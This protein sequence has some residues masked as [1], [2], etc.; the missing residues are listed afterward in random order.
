MD[1]PWTNKLYYGDNLSVL[2]ERLAEE[3]VDL[4]YLDPPFNSDADYNVLFKSHS[5]RT[6]EAQVEAFKDSWVWGEESEMAMDDVLR[7]SHTRTAEMLVSLRGFLK[8]CDLMAY[9]AMMASRMIELHRVLKETGTLYLHCDPTAAHYLKLLLDSI[10]GPERFQNEIIWQRSA[11]KG[12]SFTRFP[13]AH[14]IILAYRKGKNFTWNPIHKPHRPEYIASHYN[15]LDEATGRRYTL[16][17][18]LNPNKNRPNLTYEWNGLLK[19]WRWTRTKMQ[20]LH[21]EGR[22]VYTSSGMPRY[23]RYLDE[24]PGTT[25]TSVWTDIPPINS[26]SQERLGYPTQKPLALLERIIEAS[27][28]PGDVILD[29]FCG[30]GTAVHAAEALGRRWIGIDITHLA[31]ALIERR[32]HDAFPGADFSILGTPKDLASALDLAARDKYQFQWWAVS[33]VGARPYGGKKKGA[34][35]GIDGLLFFKPDGKNP[36]KAIVSVKGGENVGV[37]MV[38][39]LIAVIERE[40]APIG[41]LLTAALPT[42]G[43]EKE[44]ASAGIYECD[45]G[46][47]PRIQILTLAE[48]FQGARPRIP[49]IDS[50]I[51]FRTAPREKR[52]NQGALDI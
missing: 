14:D 1:A 37:D 10:F 17:N 23:K 27:S 29:P 9:L 42:K 26:Q 31:I 46:R 15:K 32:I 39:Q 13:S 11:P 22:L 51:T 12:H 24:M 5:G 44:A 2:R 43:M 47:Y 45:A 18:C 30:C 21:D 19:V 50:T 20:T 4:I 38:R 36:E 52:D 25:V 33:L 49:L 35:G 28:N 41:I 7:S 48:L 16:D 3:S 34:D 40:K 8:E 6:A